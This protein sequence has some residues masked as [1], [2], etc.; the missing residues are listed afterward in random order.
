MRLGGQW[1]RWNKRGLRV[2]PRQ[3]AGCA[4]Q[5]RHRRG[6]SARLL[7]GC[8]SRPRERVL[9]RRRAAA[10]VQPEQ[11]RAARHR[12]HRGVY[13]RLP[14]SAAVHPDRQ[15][16]WR[17]VDLDANESLG[18]TPRSFTKKPPGERR[19]VFVRDR[20]RVLSASSRNQSSPR[21]PAENPVSARLELK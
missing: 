6:R 13:E 14:D 7:R 17:D 20:S 5:G 8:V 2:V 11:H 4:R 12:G 3:Q 19:G 18:A 16:V 15:R 21:P 9:H 10:A 1:P